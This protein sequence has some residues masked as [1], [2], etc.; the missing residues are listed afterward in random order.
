MR[1][2][3]AG[4]A[5]P[6]ARPGPRQDPADGKTRRGPADGEARPTARPGPRQDPADG[7]TRPTARPS[8]AWVLAGELALIAGDGPCEARI[9]RMSG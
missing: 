7:K 8:R 9:S 5:R 3:A 2:P 1:G 4:E 6:P